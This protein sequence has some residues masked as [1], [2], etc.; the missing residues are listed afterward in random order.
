M[1]NL[2]ILTPLPIQSV[3]RRYIVAILAGILAIVLRWLLDPVL[4]HVA[5]YATIYIAVAYCAIVCGSG[6]AIISGAIGFAGVFY[7]FVDPRWSF[8]VLNV[9]QVHGIIGCV[10]VSSVLIGFGQAN[11]N[12]QLRL[13]RTIDALTTEATERQRA[14]AELRKAHDGLEQRV[15]ERTSALSH[16]LKQLESEIGV[17]EQAESQLRHLSLRLM[18]LQDEERRRIARDLH[19]TAGQT[20]AAMKMSIALIRQ[21]D[22]LAAGL[23][24]L[25]DDLD[26]LADE[27]LQEV[28]T[29]SYLLHPP[30]LDEAGIA[31]AARWF[32]EGFA[33][34][35][36]IR[37]DCKIPDKMERPSRTC[38]LVLFRV[39][40]ESLTN[41]HRHSEASAANVWLVR[42]HDMFQL[43]VS[44]NGK[45][46]SE[47][48][49]RRFETSPN[50]AGV[51]ITGMRE[52]VRE[53]GGQIEIKSLNP[54][55]CIRVTL[56]MTIQSSIP[57][58]GSPVELAS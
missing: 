9:P 54:G 57:D 56:P 22:G 2:R 29:T 43:E 23:Q 14:E 46:I 16:A 21:L 55:T 58:P 36:G 10:F 1:R 18:T 52:R 11:R 37:V 7:W 15:I 3:G 38:E 12:K 17:R 40:Q 39:L 45:G 28:R 51:G 35:S 30:L 5:F 4:G 6:P 33:R 53:L 20:L 34:R 49:L 27:A 8:Q 24:P 26:A 41:V 42:A 19:D 47:E 44:D 48:R 50:K 13:N 32:V 25:I 31:S